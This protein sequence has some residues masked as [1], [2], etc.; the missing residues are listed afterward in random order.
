MDKVR[1]DIIYGLLFAFIFSLYRMTLLT[2]E[3]K[4]FRDI[5]YGLL[6]AFI[7]SLYRMT[8]LTFEGNKFNYEGWIEEEEEEDVEEE[9]EFKDG[10]LNG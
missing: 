7:F 1:R 9:G 8:L 6:F 2:F 10:K 4:K 5:I 3:G